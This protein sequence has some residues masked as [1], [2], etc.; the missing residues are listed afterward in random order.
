MIGCS[1]PSV[2]S[3]SAT[4]L[5]ALLN[6]ISLKWFSMNDQE[7]KVFYPQS[8]KIS[9]LSGSCININDPY[10]NILM[11]RTNEA[12]QIEQNQTCR[13]KCRLDASVYNNNN[14]GMMINA[15][16]NTKN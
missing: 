8:I 6:T 2:S 10:A 1:L 12:K 11:S 4:P 9:K 3:S 13:C 15:G 16:V 14:V 5:S 7:F